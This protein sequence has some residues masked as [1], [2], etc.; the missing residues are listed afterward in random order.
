[1]IGREDMGSL[2]VSRT[3]EFVFQ[4]WYC[5]LSNKMNCSFNDKGRMTFGVKGKFM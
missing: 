3:L 4:S 2:L 1:M 5:K